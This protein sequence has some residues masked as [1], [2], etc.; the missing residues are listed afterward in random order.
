[1]VVIGLDRVRFI[2][3]AGSVETGYGRHR[4]QG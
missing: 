1:L 2:K 3:S 4:T